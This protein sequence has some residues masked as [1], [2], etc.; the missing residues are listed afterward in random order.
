MKP[1]FRFVVI[2]LLALSAMLEVSFV[3]GAPQA[4]A[5]ST[6]KETR[7]EEL[8]RLGLAVDPG[9][10]PDSA[11]VYFRYGHSYHIEKFPK[12][13]TRALAVRPGWVRP[14]PFMGAETEVYQQDEKYV[15][16]FI[17]EPKLRQVTK[18]PDGREMRVTPFTPEQVSYIQ[19]LKGEME[20]LPATPS[21]VRL[22]FEESSVGLPDS[23]SWR[24]GVAIAD[25]NEDGLPDIVAPPQRSALDNA[26][27]IFLGD[28][29]GGWKL[30]EI[31]WPI[32]FAYGNVAVGDLNRDGHLDLVFA[33]HL[34]G[35]EVLLGDGKGH[36]TESVKGMKESFPTRKV[37]LMDLDGNGSLDVIAVT[38]GPKP[39]MTEADSTEESKL[40]GFLND[41]KATSWKKIEIA[42]PELGMGGDWMATGDFD[43]DGKR[44]I[45]TSSNYFSSPDIFYLGQGK[46]AWKPFGRGFL[47]F[48]S[49]YYSPVAAKFTSSKRD[50][51][52]LTYVR[53]WPNTID[54]ELVAWPKI[55]AIVGIERVSWQ[56]GKPVR[57]P[58]TR[59]AGD[60]AV[61]GMDAADFDGDGHLD[62][63]F[64]KGS[65]RE[66]VILLGDG[67]GQFRKSRIS[68]IEV[69]KNSSYDVVAADVNGD[70]RPDIIIPY[71]DE[72]RSSS[73]SVRVYLNHGPEKKA[74]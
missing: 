7:S 33:V 6:I 3:S 9:P 52:I 68:G 36:F 45:V 54:P 16:V 10:D 55:R 73:G 12:K 39:H 20:E 35:V 18:D 53:A 51:V 8:K 59:W 67:K 62:I 43:G 47:P 17:P 65:P 22:S 49:Y 63:A 57:T 14:S 74:R 27:A 38:E 21:D 40:I 23:G 19:V 44:D 30:W 13:D 28:G 5:A 26:P 2:P 34:T 11:K 56:G 60:N 15:W 64:M 46:S 61:W 37:K 32:S 31:S 71:E 29:K 42:K 24:N 1:S 48:Y 50:D 25:M 41:G 4:A 70:G 66:L 69:P 72:H 58:I